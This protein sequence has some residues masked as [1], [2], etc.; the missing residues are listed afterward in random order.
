VTR[1]TDR[2][3]SLGLVILATDDLPR[4]RSFY[5]S[6]FGWPVEVDTSVY[7]ELRLPA[8][9]RLGLYERTAF[10]RNVGEVP[11]RAPADTLAA[12][13]LYLFPDDL[14]AAIARLDEA[15]ARPL[16][17]LARRAWGDEVAYFADPDGNVLAVARRPPD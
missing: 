9:M 5:E 7:V 17:P 6:A 1:R 10:G 2:P 11:R 12:T 13:E 4:S 14:D 3:A 15:R 8:G 16:S